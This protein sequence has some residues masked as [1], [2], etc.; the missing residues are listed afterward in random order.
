MMSAKIRFRFS[1]FLV[2]GCLAILFAC[3]E[4]PTASDSAGKVYTPVTIIPVTLKKVTSIIDLPATSVFMNKN[5]IRARTTGTI[6]KIL[7][8]Q[9]DFAGQDQLLF[10][11]RTREAGAISSSTEN[12]STLSFSGLISITAKEAGVINSISYQK[13]DFVQEGDEIAVISEQKSLA[14]ILDVPYE[15]RSIAD[16]NSECPIYLPDGKIIKGSIEGKLPEMEIQSQ[17]IRYIIKP[18]LVNQLPSNLIARVSLVRSSNPNA[19]VVPK[20][21]VLSNETQ[22][23]FWVMKVINDSTAIRVNIT[24][25]N[26]N[27][28]EIEIIEPAFLESDRIV[29]KGN[30]GLADTAGI[31][32]TGQN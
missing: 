27:N 29:L 24:K 1:I 23:E 30:Y 21:A 14:F 19:T 8:S 9:G 3:R 5:I 32:I 26:E 31:S 20:E 28:D 18:S 4:T 15:Y 12:D 11:I 7:I 16:R 17:T 10:T 22:T 13:G 6:D 2:P 25:G